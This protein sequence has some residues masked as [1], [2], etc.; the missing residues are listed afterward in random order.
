MSYHSLNQNIYFLPTLY[1]SSWQ[2]ENGHVNLYVT[3]VF[4]FFRKVLTSCVLVG[5]LHLL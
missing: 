3:P 4:V 1:F 2:E 5:R